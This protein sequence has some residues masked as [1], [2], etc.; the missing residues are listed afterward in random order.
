MG[1]ST[2][3]RGARHIGIGDEGEEGAGGG[4]DTFTSEWDFLEGKGGTSRHLERKGALFKG[5]CLISVV[6]ILYMCMF[7]VND[8]ITS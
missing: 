4:R 5:E 1:A 2:G 8:R 7:I 3:C 6:C